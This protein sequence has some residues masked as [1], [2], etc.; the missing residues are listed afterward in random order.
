VF[1]APVISHVAMHGFLKYHFP[2]S[3][4]R[5][6]SL[7][8]TTPIG[9]DINP[10][11]Y[12][13][14]KAGEMELVLEKSGGSEN[15]YI[16]YNGGESEAEIEGIKMKKTAEGGTERISFSLPDWGFEN[17]YI[18]FFNGQEVKVV[19]IYASAG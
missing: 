7:T 19:P 11:D 1:A 13:F 9:P 10:D 4:F 5:L 17:H 2:E 8:Y 15:L 18:L 3:S 14:Y 12:R 6:M 16:A